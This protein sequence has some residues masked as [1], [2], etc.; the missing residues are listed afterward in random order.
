MLVEVQEASAEAKGNDPGRA[1]MTVIV[2]HPGD[3]LLAPFA[4]RMGR[5]MLGYGRAMVALRTIAETVEG[6]RNYDLLT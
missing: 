3:P 2:P 4:E 1:P 5:M 6:R